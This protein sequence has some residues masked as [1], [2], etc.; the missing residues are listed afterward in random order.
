M[1]FRT[2]LLTASI[3]AFLSCN[4]NPESETSLVK[5]DSVVNDLNIAED[6]S[7]DTQP[8]TKDQHANILSIVQ[9]VDTTILEADYIQYLTGKEAIEEAA[10]AGEVDTFRTKDG[11]IELVVPND[12]YIANKSKKIRKLYLSKDCAFDLLHNPDRAN[13]ISGNSLKSLKTIY[14]E[15]PFLLTIDK[16]GFVVKIKEVFTP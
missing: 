3:S 12:Y 14:R 5:P 7:P 2:I 9:K 1:T 10:K 13:P 4:S 16:S 15:S 8:N 11:S 6:D